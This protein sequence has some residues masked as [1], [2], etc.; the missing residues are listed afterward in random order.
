[1][2]WDP[3]FLGYINHTV[4]IPIEEHPE[5][6]LHQP[7]IDYRE[8]LDEK[9]GIVRVAKSSLGR[10]PAFNSPGRGAT[11]FTVTFRAEKTGITT[12]NLTQSDL[13]IPFVFP[14]LA[15]AG[16]TVPHWAIDA[17]IEVVN[18]DAEARVSRSRAHDISANFLLPIGLAVTAGTVVFVIVLLRTRKTCRFRLLNR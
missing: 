9:T 6:V 12:L 14:E 17:R 4:K 16:Q 11:V 1:M 13:A 15:D 7:I 18:D 5:G 2:R 10:V 3:S 8:I